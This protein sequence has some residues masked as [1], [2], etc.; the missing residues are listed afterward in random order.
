MFSSEKL[1]QFF[2]I[3]GEWGHKFES[4]FGHIPQ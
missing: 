4:R 2:S 3:G 1:V